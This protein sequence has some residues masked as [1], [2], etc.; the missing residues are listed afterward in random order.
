[1]ISVSSAVIAP[2]NPLAKQS[3]NCGGNGNFVLAARQWIGRF[4]AWFG[5]LYLPVVNRR[6]TRNFSHEP[7]T[8]SLAAV[9]A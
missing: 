2:V 8:Q 5:G 9:R 7:D 6:I 3:G 1:M 4:P